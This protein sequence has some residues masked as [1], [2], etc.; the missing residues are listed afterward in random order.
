MLGSGTTSILHSTNPHLFCYQRELNGKRLQ[1]VVTFS[2]HPQYWH[3][4]RSGSFTDA[5]TGNKLQAGAVALSAY[6]VLWLTN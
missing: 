4:D 2:E 1:V 3:S 5:L 6:Q